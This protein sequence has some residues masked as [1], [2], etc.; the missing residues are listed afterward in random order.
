M[1]ISLFSLLMPISFCSTIPSIGFGTAGLGPATEAALNAALLAGYPVLDVASTRGPWYDSE[2]LAHT[3][4]NA[5]RTIVTKVHPFDLSADGVAWSIC[6][7]TYHLANRPMPPDSRPREGGCS[8]DALVAL[9]SD[10]PCDV[11]VLLHYPRCW[12]SLCDWDSVRFTSDADRAAALAYAGDDEAD[13]RRDWRV[14]YRVL[15]D[16]Q[17][18][19][20]VDGIGVSNFNAAE[21]AELGQLIAASPDTLVWPSQV[22]GWADPFWQARAEREAAAAL[23]ARFVAYSSLGTQWRNGNPIAS[24][25]VLHDIATSVDRSVAQVVLRYLLQREVAVIPRSS[26]PAHIEE[27]LRLGDFEL[28][29]EQLAAIDA[30]DG[31]AGHP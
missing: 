15:S 21:L 2:P 11:H 10:R 26:S 28:S 25:T 17:S 8:I 9:A 29:D 16:A 24:S 18:A 22:Q 3:W 19:R 7:S 13:A 4:C 1:F 5:G 14:A 27:N 12:G 6:Q 31:T 30:L 20:L 23:G